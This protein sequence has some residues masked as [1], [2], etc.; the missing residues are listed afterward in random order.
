MSSSLRNAL[1]YIAIGLVFGL[2]WASM[3]YANGQI[4]DPVALAGPVIALGAAGLLMWLLRCLV[5]RLRNR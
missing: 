5:V 4:R 2:I 1:R 3:Q